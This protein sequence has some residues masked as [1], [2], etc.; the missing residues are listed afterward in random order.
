MADKEALEVLCITFSQTVRALV[1]PSSCEKSVE[2]VVTTIRL[3]LLDF[4][5]KT[6]GILS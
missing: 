4:K 6:G 1:L 3:F 5:L 2:L